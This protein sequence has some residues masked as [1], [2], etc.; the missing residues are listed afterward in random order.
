MTR[1]DDFH[2]YEGIGRGGF[3]SVHRGVA[4]ATG[5]QVAI[6][7]IDKKQMNASGIKYKIWKKNKIVNTN[8]KLR[9]A[10]ILD[11]MRN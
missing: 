6:K 7:M 2:V 1:I 3:A 4:K 10:Q 11:I 8:Q 5:R 9:I